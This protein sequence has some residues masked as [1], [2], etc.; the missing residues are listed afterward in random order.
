MSLRD[1][2]NKR[3]IYK[4][5]ENNLNTFNNYFQINK[6][7]SYTEFIKRY[8]NINKD[9]LQQEI[10]SMEISQANNYEFSSKY[11]LAYYYVIITLIFKEL[12]PK[13][14]YINILIYL[15]GFIP[16]EN[17]NFKEIIEKELNSFLSNDSIYSDNDDNEY[18]NETNLKNFYYP[19]YINNQSYINENGDNLEN[20]NYHYAQSLDFNAIEKI[21]NSC[22]NSEIK[23]RFNMIKKEEQLFEKRNLKDII[24][25]F[26]RQGFKIIKDSYT[27]SLTNKFM[28]K[29]YKIGHFPRGP[30]LILISGYYSSNTDHYE[31]WSSLIEVYKKKFKNPI[32]YYFNWPSSH[33]GLDQ[34]IF[35]KTDFIDAKMRGSY[36]GKL[37]ALMI[38]SNKFFS[39]FKI[40]FVAFSL[41]TQV[42]KHCIKELAI[43]GKLSII[44][45]IVFLGGAA[46]INNCFKWEKRLNTFKGV[47]INCYSIIDILLSYCQSITNKGTIGTK[48]LK[49]DGVK[50][51]NYS[52]NLL[53]IL[54]RLKMDKIG[55]LILKNLIE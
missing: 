38:M 31:E 52:V 53:H 17:K 19:D 12:H 24:L 2:D 46:N 13:S 34:L 36:C 42:L 48:K 4:A 14:I 23:N 43:S 8:I 16:E 7:N 5:T 29:P 44:N 15:Q 32:I 1:V 35:H 54:Y 51:T 39:G 40:N 21:I 25:D 22:N 6:V 18:K 30:I 10:I 20:D 55:N 49:I 3:D 45:N 9:E 47:I 41:G 33:Y 26:L 37:L 50:I 27:E 28:L 11:I